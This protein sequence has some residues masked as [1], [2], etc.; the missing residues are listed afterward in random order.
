MP[1][2]HVEMAQQCETKAYRQDRKERGEAA[3]DAGMDGA[4]NRSIQGK[5]RH[6]I[7]FRSRSR[8]AV[9]SRFDQIRSE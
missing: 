4:K 5:L 3:Y 2:P 7:V 6:V 1:K 9:R 8:A